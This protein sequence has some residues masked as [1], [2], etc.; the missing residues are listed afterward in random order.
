MLCFSEIAKNSFGKYFATLLVI[1]VAEH[2]SQGSCEMSPL[3]IGIIMIILGGWFMV[4][5]SISFKENGI[6]IQKHDCN[7]ESII[8]YD[9]P[10]ID[11]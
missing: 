11:E 3:N 7:D 10:L 1:K 4:K 6:H 5:H 8:S 9:K 2:I